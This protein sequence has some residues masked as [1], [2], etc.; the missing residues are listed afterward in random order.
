MA[1]ATT[2]YRPY[3]GQGLR[4]PLEIVGGRL[5]TSRGERKIEEA[6]RHILGTGLGER[7]MRPDF[8]CGVHD[9]VFAPNNSITVNRIVD[10]VQ[11]ALAQYEPRIDVLEVTAESTPERP[12]LLLIRIAYRIRE[13][14]AIGNVVYPF[15]VTEGV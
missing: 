15:F 6:I 12:N 7:L 13:N 2:A 10:H 11:R 4:F 9:L 14:N 1:H 3:L 8:G 5:M